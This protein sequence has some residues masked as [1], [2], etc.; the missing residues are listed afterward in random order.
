[1]NASINESLPQSRLKKIIKKIVKGIA[2]FIAFCITGIIICLTLL[3]LEHKQ[4]VTLPLPTGQFA[5][6]RTSLGG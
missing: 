4:S 6:G 5:V 3:W 2:W 1:M